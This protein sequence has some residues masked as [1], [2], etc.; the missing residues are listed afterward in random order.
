MIL[1]ELV[2][3]LKKGDLGPA[4]A[5]VRA[6]LAS[7]KPGEPEALLAD[8]PTELRGRVALLLRDLLSRYPATLVGAPVLLYC[9]PDLDADAH[10]CLPPIDQV[11]PKRRLPFPSRQLSQPCS[12]L[13]FLGWLSL[14]T[15]LPVELP[16]QPAQHAVEIPQREPVAAVALFRSHPGVFDLDTLSLPDTWW[17]EVFLALPGQTRLSA[18]MLLPYPDAL[19]AARV[20]HASARGESLPCRGGFLSDN[21]WAWAGDA[22]ALFQESCRHWYPAMP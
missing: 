12:D 7:A 2:A 3:A 13:H 15:Q 1:P 4:I 6:W 17:A 18:R 11:L 20:L 14:D 9:V 10:D 19:E 22:G 21:A 8:C 5:L 16:F